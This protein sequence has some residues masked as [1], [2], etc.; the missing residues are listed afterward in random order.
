M[1]KNK[2]INIF[3]KNIIKMKMYKHIDI[4]LPSF[5]S[6]LNKLWLKIYNAY[7]IVITK[8]KLK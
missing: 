6:F 2:K 1:Y 3:E 8:S 5:T 7:K 4:I